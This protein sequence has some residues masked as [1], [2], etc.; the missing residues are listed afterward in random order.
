MRRARG[1]PPD[2][3][4]LGGDH[5]H[6]PERARPLHAGVGGADAAAS[7]IAGRDGERR[8]R[9]VAA[10]RRG[11]RGAPGWRGAHGHGRRPGA[12]ARRRG[13]GLG[14]A[15]PGHQHAV[16]R[17]PAG[18]RRVG[19]SA[20]ARRRAG[21]GQELGRGVQPALR[22]V[23]PRLVRGVQASPY[24]G[25]RAARRGTPAGH[26]RRPQAGLERRGDAAGG[27][28]RDARARCTRRA[29]HRRRRLDGDGRARTADQPPV[30]SGRRA[31]RE[32]RPAGAAVIATALAASLALATPQAQ[33]P[34]TVWAVGDGADGSAIARRLA[35]RI[36]RSRPEA[37]L[38]LGDVY[39]GGTWADYQR[40]W[41]P[42]YG[43]LDPITW[44]T[45]GNHEWWAREQGYYA[46]WRKHRKAK[47]WQR[48]SV[49]G[50]EILSLNSETDHG[51]GSPQLRWPGR[52][53]ARR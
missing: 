47:P 19:R 27:R 9:H 30:G 15:R 16:F 10:G 49:A 8:A 45:P 11:E 41:R 26:G 38:Y 13:R 14:G 1:R 31:P 18:G 36:E 3:A 46:Y 29:E 50:W 5:L 39:P 21:A 42:V 17:G 32:R 44:P 25:R 40:N 35:R 28:A 2:R 22:P 12:A 23:V 4:P 34:A 48:F 20:A 43:R 6:R 53:L 24:H 51:P 7:R 33:E 37:F 52:G